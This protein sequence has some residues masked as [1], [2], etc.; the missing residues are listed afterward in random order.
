[1]DDK[2]KPHDIIIPALGAIAAMLLLIVL[3][4]MILRGC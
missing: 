2:L 4:V 3:P 1:M